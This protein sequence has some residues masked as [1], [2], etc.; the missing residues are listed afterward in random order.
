MAISHAIK[1]NSISINA[2]SRETVS[3]YIQWLKIN[4]FF[5]FCRHTDCCWSLLIR[6]LTFTKW[7]YY[8]SHSF[9]ADRTCN[10]PLYFL[11]SCGTGSYECW[12]MERYSPEDSNSCSSLNLEKSVRPQNAQKAQKAQKSR[13]YS[14]SYLA[15]DRYPKSEWLSPSLTSNF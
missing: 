5:A 10:R 13:K 1:V 3:C 14:M 2:M 6:H 4:L 15:L 12:G 9:P 11:V 7:G 8:N